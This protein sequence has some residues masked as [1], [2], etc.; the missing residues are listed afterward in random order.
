MGSF[1]FVFFTVK[2][3]ILCVYYVLCIISAKETFVYL[4]EREESVQPNIEDLTKVCQWYTPQER[5]W[6]LG[7]LWDIAVL[8]QASVVLIAI[9]GML[10]IGFTT[11][12][13]FRHQSQFKAMSLFF[14]FS[15]IGNAFPLIL[16]Y[17]SDFCAINEGVCNDAE[18]FCVSSCSWG[19]GSWQT[20]AASFLWLTTA[21]T[22]WLINPSNYK[23]KRTREKANR[24]KGESDESS[25]DTDDSRLSIH[26]ENNF[27]EQSDR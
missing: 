25:Y 19:R 3:L 17:K 2:S 14:C 21:F 13:A 27:G 15:A 16:Q 5:E 9:V 7:N 26:Y 11:C 20:L 4:G 24:S 10:L 18:T 6:L 12:Y 23:K 8:S 1:I 22:T